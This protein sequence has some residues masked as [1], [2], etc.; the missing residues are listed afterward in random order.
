MKKENL[1]SFY[2]DYHFI[3]A[4]SLDEKYKDKIYP[5][6]LMAVVIR[7]SKP[8]KPSS[9]I[10]T[11][12]KSR[13]A[14]K[15]YGSYSSFMEETNRNISKI[16]SEFKI[17]LPLDMKKEVKKAESNGKKVVLLLPPSGKVPIYLGIDTQKYIKSKKILDTKTKNI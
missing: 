4:T 15:S 14:K 8:R 2:A 13:R 1:I 16:K 5:I 11:V 10:R 7:I 9:V 3:N 12:E 6:V 17:H